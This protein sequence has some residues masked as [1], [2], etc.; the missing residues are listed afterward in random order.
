M[1]EQ[2][3]RSK[4][5]REKKKIV[6]IMTKIYLSIQRAD[7]GHSETCPSTIPFRTQ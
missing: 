5:A 7:L 2:I 1:K 3:K 6:L 4:H